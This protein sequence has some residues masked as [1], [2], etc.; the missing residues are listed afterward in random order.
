MTLKTQEYLGIQIDYDKEK[1][2]SQFSL[3]TL[4]D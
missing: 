4:K 2:L 1:E 3:D